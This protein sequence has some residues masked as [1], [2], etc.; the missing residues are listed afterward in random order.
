MTKY[1]KSRT[2]GTL[3]G[4]GTRQCVSSISPRLPNEKKYDDTD[5]DDNGNNNNIVSVRCVQ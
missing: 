4:T 3:F 5:D 1:F 2:E